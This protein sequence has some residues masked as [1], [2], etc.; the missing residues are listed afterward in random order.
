[1]IKRKVNLFSFPT[2]RLMRGHK[3]L[4][5][6]RV[7]SIV[8]IVVLFLLILIN[9]LY[10]AKVTGDTSALQL[11][12]E[13]LHEA[14]KKDSI[15]QTEIQN[16]ATRI[17]TIREALS[18]DIAFASSS[19][20]LRDTFTSSKLGAS[21][22]SISFTS[23]KDFSVKISF[24]SQND[25]LEFVRVSETDAFKKRFKNMSVGEFA[26]SISSKSAEMN[27]IDF[28]GTFL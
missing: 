23:K 22:E 21:F 6:I 1:M 27:T 4:Q 13:M 15:R 12:Q 7:V 20:R 2:R 19:A 16:I 11:E 14:I 3:R 18:R 28:S 9:Y 5:Y 26:V 8:C 24:P 17:R 25:V 10:Q